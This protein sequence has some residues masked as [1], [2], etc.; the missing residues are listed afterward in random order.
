M[1]NEMPSNTDD[2]SPRDDEAW[3]EFKRRMDSQPYLEFYPRAEDLRVGEYRGFSL[4]MAIWA[5]HVLFTLPL[6]VITAIWNGLK[7]F[8]M[9][10]AGLG[11]GLIALFVSPFNMLFHRLL[12]TIGALA[13]RLWIVPH[14]RSIA[15]H[16]NHRLHSIRKEME[17]EGYNV[18]R[19]FHEVDA[20][21]I[22]EETREHL[23]RRWPSQ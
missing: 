4:S 5:R 20:D 6:D 22:S 12:L 7:G 23:L 21:E 1:S 11:M 15:L 17:S 18:D 3:E 19:F 8:G 13:G 16:L 2:W 9:G 14:N 10:I